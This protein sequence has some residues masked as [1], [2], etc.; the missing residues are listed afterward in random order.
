LTVKFEGFR[1]RNHVLELDGLSLAQLAEKFG[2]PC[3]VY[4]ADLIV[5][6]YRQM[7]VALGQHPHQVCYAVKANPNLSILKLLGNE[8]CG[9][10][11]VSG[12]ELFRALEAGIPANRI[13]FDGVGKSKEEIDYALR[14]KILYFNVESEQELV[15]I[16]VVAKEH[17]K[18]A[19]IAFR[20]NPDVNPRTHPHIAT[21]LKKTKFGIPVKKAPEIIKAALRL[22]NVHVMGLSCHIG[23]QILSMSPFIESARK[24][25]KLYDKVSEWTD[26]I[27]HINF[28][29]GL[30]ITYKTEKPPQLASWAQQLVKEIGDRPLTVLFEPGRSLVGNAGVLLSRVA[31]VKRGESDSFIILDTGMNDL[32]RP[33]L[34][35]AYHS[36][37]P[38]RFKKYKKL[39]ASIV[40][41]VCETGDILAK[42]RRVP[43]LQQGDLVSIMSCGAYAASM[44]NQYNSRP[45]PPEILVYEGKAHVIRERESYEDLIAK[46][47]PPSGLKKALSAFS[48]I[49]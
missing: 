45:R 42:D 5:S 24:L 11:V 43:N 4:S 14:K 22:K 6:A 40:G 34:Y 30:G 19:P 17:K 25:L 33:A 46:E 41:P 20:I 47:S 2:T 21:G 32:P 26:G 3:Y 38:V 29:G 37:L 35:D 27:S 28:G 39:K 13:I 18:V 15:Q 9:A 16:D 36:I 8:G 1:Y 49:A 12:G 31:Y 10:E 23:S 44:G 48:V 7:I